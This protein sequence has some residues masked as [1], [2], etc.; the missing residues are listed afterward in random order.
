MKATAYL[1]VVVDR[2]TYDGR[3][4]SL[5]VGRTTAKKPGAPLPN[6]VVV[7]FTV[8]V[9]TILFEPLIV[10]EVSI[11]IPPLVSSAVGEYVGRG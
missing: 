9:P 5:K 10:N 1:Q 7:K 4:Y 11:A 8:D 6:A 2:T 3:P